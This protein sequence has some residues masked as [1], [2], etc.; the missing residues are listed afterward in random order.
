[1]HGEGDQHENVPGT[2]DETKVIKGTAE[3][4]DSHSRG[5]PK[6]GDYQEIEIVCWEK[7]NSYQGENAHEYREAGVQ[8]SDKKKHRLNMKRKRQKHW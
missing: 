5:Q 2:I 7:K 3:E 1:V 4:T 8:A 6:L